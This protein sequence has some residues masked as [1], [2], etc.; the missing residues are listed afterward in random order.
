MMTKGGG[1]HWHQVS[2]YVVSYN[3]NTMIA[4][5]RDRKKQR[6]NAL[7]TIVE[8]LKSQS[9]MLEGEASNLR[10]ENSEGVLNSE[11]LLLTDMHRLAIEFA[12]IG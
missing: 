4:R 7:E 9:E 2:I 11:T 6:E 8:R 3:S 12:R 10:K 1:I 5:F